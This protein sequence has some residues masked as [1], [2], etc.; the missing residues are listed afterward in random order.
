MQDYLQTFVLFHESPTFQ[1][2]SLALFVPEVIIEDLVKFY[3]K[4]KLLIHNGV[5]CLRTQFTKVKS[6]KTKLQKESISYDIKRTS[7][8]TKNI[9]MESS[10]LNGTA[11]G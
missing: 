3:F 5:N 10:I 2:Q 8:D 4:H 1:L 6:S 9:E 11:P 7:F